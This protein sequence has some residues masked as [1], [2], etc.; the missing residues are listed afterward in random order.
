[1]KTKRL[2]PTFVGALLLFLI[3]NTIVGVSELIMNVRFNLLLNSLL[4]LFF[5]L[6][7]I[8]YFTQIAYQLVGKTVKI[9]PFY[10][11]LYKLMRGDKK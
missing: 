8:H 4:F 3:F 9:E 1:M 2:L 5:Y 11:S 10:I 6:I 7:A